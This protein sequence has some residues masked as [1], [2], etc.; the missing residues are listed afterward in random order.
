MRTTT[1]CALG[2][3]IVGL[4]VVTNARSALAVDDQ[5]CSDFPSQ[6]A[7]QQH[8]RADPSD[9]D[10]LDANNDGVACESNPA[11]Y[12]RQPVGTGSSAPSPTSPPAYSAPPTN[13]PVP[14]T[15]AAPH[16]FAAT[17]TSPPSTTSTTVAVTTTIR[18]TATTIETVAIKDP[19]RKLDAN[20]AAKSTKP[21]EASPA[22]TAL[23]FAILGGAI[24]GAIRWRRHRRTA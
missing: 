5:N 2:A 10:N 12:D 14:A 22:E 16:N 3:A 23:G 6:A 4:A 19:V 8:L 17:A 11:P 9:P 7:A 20:V 1:R 21:E 18:P 15:T 24:Y 13:K